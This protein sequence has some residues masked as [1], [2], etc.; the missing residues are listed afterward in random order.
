MNIHVTKEQYETL[1]KL[2]QYGYWVAS[3]DQETHEAQEFGEMEQYILSLAKDFGF[4]GVEWDEEYN[5][6]DVTATCKND[7]QQVIDQYEEMVFK[8]KLAYY[9]AR[10]DLAREMTEHV[11]DEERAFERIVELEEEYHLH[12]E[13]HGV[14]HLQIDKTK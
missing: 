9:L 10:R 8:D 6:Y 13:K 4:D 3:S 1:L 5:L 11:Y 14:D 12:L 7:I 2:V